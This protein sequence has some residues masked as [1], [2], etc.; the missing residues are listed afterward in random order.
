MQLRLRELHGA[1]LLVVE[2]DAVDDGLEIRAH[3]VGPFSGG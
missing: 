1:E 2:A 3:R